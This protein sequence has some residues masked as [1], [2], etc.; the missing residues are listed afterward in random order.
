MN[1][2]LI[3][4]EGYVGSFVNDYLNKNGH[5]IIS[6]DLSTSS[7]YCN[8]HYTGDYASLLEL[9]DINIDVVINLAAHSS[10]KMSDDEPIRAMENNVINL[11]S[12][13]LKCKEFKIPFIYA[14]SGSIYSSINDS[15]FSLKGSSVNIYD[16]SKMAAD[17][18]LSTLDIPS[19][20]L[21]FGTV[22]GWSR[23]VRNEL[24][25]NSMNI[26]AKRDKIVKIWN[27]EN[28]RSILFLDD[29]V[30][31]LDKIL[32]NINYINKF[33]RVQLYSWSGSINDL[34]TIIAQHWGADLIFQ[35]G[36]GTY[37]FV[38]SDHSFKFSFN[39]QILKSDIVNQCNLFI[40]KWTHND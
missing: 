16:G 13:A 9:I 36:D 31:Y 33:H 32:E 28:L 22:S 12:L 23:R 34:G 7:V 17:M 5:S 1:I 35:R 38:L 40:D 26:S 4:S 21:C 15:N 11:L 2:L 8:K 20:A 3:G 10:V 14:S 24:I 29:L 37:S 25:F 19:V 39:S 30:K 6:C 27:G 18:I